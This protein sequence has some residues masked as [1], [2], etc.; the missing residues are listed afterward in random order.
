M[1]TIPEST[2]IDNPE[3]ASTNFF[4]TWDTNGQIFNMQTTV[5]GVLTFEQVQAHI[6]TAMEAVAHVQSLGGIAKQIGR[7]AEQPVSKEPLPMVIPPAATAQDSTPK[8]Q[9]AQPAPDDLSFVTET[10]SVSIT[11]EKK[12]FKVKGGKYSKFGV[13]AWPEVLH[14]IGMNTENAEAKE[15]PFPGYKATYVLKDGKPSKVTK[16]EKVA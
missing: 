2:K 14:S 15:Y 8:E 11:N 5:R 9:P 16:L 4:W 13:T 1:T 7:G 3:Q 12:F 10:I 6:K